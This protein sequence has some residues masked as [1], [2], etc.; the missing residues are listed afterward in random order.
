L[1][2]VTLVGVRVAYTVEQCW[3]EVPGGTAV[4]A[5]ALA[6]ELAQRPDVTLVGVSAHHR[7]E[8]DPP[9]VPPVPVRQLPLPRSALYEAWRRL[10]WPRV[11]QATGPVDLVHATTVIVPPRRTCPLVVTVHDLAFLH[12]PGQFSGHG[13]R[14]FR[15]GLRRIRRHADVVLCSSQATMDDCAAAGVAGDRLRLVPL[16]IDPVER[17]APHEMT[18]VRRR[19]GLGQPYL[20]FVGTLEPRKNLSRLVEAVESRPAGHDLVV[21]GPTGWGKSPPTSHRV[22]FVGFV[23]EP[24]KAALYAG[25]DV[26]CYPSLREGFG[27]PVLEAMAYGV[28]VVTSKD[29]ATAEVGG[30]A[31]VLVDPRSSV[32]IARGIAEAMTRRDELSVAGTVRAAQ[33]TWAATADRVLSAYKEVLS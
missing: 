7:G 27:L 4:A 16:G 10:G 11:E 8:P 28:P 17:P 5:V 15:A 20:L 19:L 33:F 25:A 30:D 24:T 14:S 23:D 2:Q 13:V 6:R 22:R 9:F 29:T 31:V 12:D 3:H 18:E 1:R 26:V 32:D 21:V